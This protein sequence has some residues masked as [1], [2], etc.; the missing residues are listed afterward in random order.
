MAQIL[1]VKRA[2]EAVLKPEG[3]SKNGWQAIREAALVPTGRHSCSLMQE[4]RLWLAA[5]LRRVTPQNQPVTSVMVSHRYRECSG[6]LSK[7]LPG[8]IQIPD[9][10]SLPRTC[11]GWELPGIIESFTGYRPPDD[12]LADWFR[13]LDWGFNFSRHDSYSG[14]QQHELICL[15]VRMRIAER[16][17]AS[18]RA[19]Q[20]FH[21]HTAA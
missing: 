11:Q 5:S 16:Q 14:S 7:A 6:D 17:R 1:D 3:Y 10:K 13:K 19:A 9:V 4:K 8:F 21:Q 2:I 12:R 20:N 18:R 15:W